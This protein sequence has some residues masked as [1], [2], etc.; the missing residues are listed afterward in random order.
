MSL[1]ASTSSCVIGVGCSHKFHF[2]PG[3]RNGACSPDPTSAMATGYVF[4]M[5][6]KAGQSSFIELQN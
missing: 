3:S 1:W 5:S 6:P 2:F 4:C